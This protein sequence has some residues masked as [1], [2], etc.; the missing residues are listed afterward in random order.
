MPDSICPK[1]SL[2]HTPDQRFSSF[3]C[4]SPLSALSQYSAW[5]RELS[6]ILGPQHSQTWGAKSGV[7]LFQASGKSVLFSCLPY[8]LSW[9]VPAPACLYRT[10]FP[11]NLPFKT[12]M[13][14]TFSCLCIFTLL[15]DYA[16]F[17]PRC[18]PWV[19]GSGLSHISVLH[20][21]PLYDFTLHTTFSVQ[22]H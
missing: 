17:L 4:F 20:F 2:I 6:G 19:D 15:Q 11:T 12:V 1:G 22:F 9:F 21:C 5:L 10:S 13:S 18:Q 3:L 16:C 7:Q 14:L 8:R